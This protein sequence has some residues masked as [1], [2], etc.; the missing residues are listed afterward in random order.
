MP[1]KDLA[2]AGR[3]GSFASSDPQVFRL[4][5]GNLP[6]LRNGKAVSAVPQFRG[7]TLY[8]Q[9]A[10]NAPAPFATANSNTVI[11]WP[12]NKKQTK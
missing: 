1:A 3:S 11:N 4:R 2:Y 8:S 6:T 5:R 7:I 12:Q 9:T 10:G